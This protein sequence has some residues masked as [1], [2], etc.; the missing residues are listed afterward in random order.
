MARIGFPIWVAVAAAAVPALAAIPAV[1]LQ[2]GPSKLTMQL[3]TGFCVPR[4]YVAG[5]AD[6]VAKAD[7]MNVT[8][9][10]LVNC[11]HQD[12]EGAMNNYLIIKA[13]KRAL[14]LN[15]DKA[16]TLDQLDKAAAG[17]NAPIA[18]EQMLKGT[19]DSLEATTGQR[20]ELAGKVAYA[21]RDADC[22]YLAGRMGLKDK[23]EASVLVAAC[24]TIAAGKLI[25]VYRY[26]SRPTA[27]VTSLK[28]QV[29][30]IANS[31]HKPVVR[32][33]KPKRRG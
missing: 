31:I 14:M 26:D 5:V 23:P 17:P 32:G 27:D 9:A 4:G 18:D 33:S 11:E 10:T 7:D 21:G 6:A 15:F 28:A 3:P 12:D 29:R 25:T 8:L 24:T 30:A 19:T 13:Y 16:S 2:V 1:M 22:I 20:M